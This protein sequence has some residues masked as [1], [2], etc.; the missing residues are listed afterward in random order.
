M[1]KTKKKP[2]HIKRQLK[3]Y[4]VLYVI[5]LLAIVYYFVF[6]Y[7]PLIWGVEISFKDMK[8]GSTIQDAPWVGWKNYKYFFQNKS[9]LKL[10][11]NTLI[12]SINSMIWGF[13]PPILLT[14]AIFDL[15]SKKYQK[16]CQTMVYIP[17]FFS[18]VIIYGIV[19]AFF[20]GNGFVNGIIR[21]LG[22]T[23]VGF[24]T[25]KKAF[26]PLL[27]GTQIWQSVGWSTIL[28]FAAL[29]SVDTELYDAAKID[30]AGPIQRIRAVTFPAMKPVITFSLI[31]SLGGVLGT[32]FEQIMMFY[33]SA[34]YDVADVIDTWVYRVGLGQMQYGYGTATS[35]MRSV[36]GL[37]LMVSANTI[38]KKVSGRGMF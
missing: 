21:A 2:G 9:M 27:I 30:G 24:L 13:L 23:E 6:M 26:L 28:Y 4:S 32:N 37:V 19:F 10:L 16:F 11:R 34:L 8:I 17:H 31:M 22:G 33:N 35:M 25:S 14:I 18:W 20:S 3:R 1:Q 29:T 12:I 15:R 5:L 7:V 38:S 36:V